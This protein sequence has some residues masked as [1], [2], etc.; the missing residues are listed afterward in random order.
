[1]S[2]YRYIIL[3]FS[4]FSLFA[5]AQENEEIEMMEFG[6]FDHWFVREIEE[7][8]VVGGN[9]LYIYSIGKSDTLRNNESIKALQYSPWG[10]SNVMARIAGITK[11]TN[12]VFPVKRDNGYCARIET[13]LIELKALGFVN[14][15][16]VTAGAIYLGGASEPVNDPN[17]LYINV[18]MG[19]PFNKKPKAIMLD[20]RSDM[21]NLTTISRSKPG[22]FSVKEF[23]G[24]DNADVFCFLQKRWEDKDGNIYA[25]RVGTAREFFGEYNKKWV[26]NHRI[27]II[28][29]NATKSPDYK[30]YMKLT[31]KEK[32]FYARN[33]KGEM[34][35]VI[36]TDWG[37]ENDEVTHI[38][39][40][41]SSGS[42]GAYEGGLNNAFLVDNIKFV[43]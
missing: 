39:F 18:D 25:K 8:R 29:G 30:D 20:Y 7:S 9:T 6:D 33:S 35:P 28:Y 38:V 3:F 37:S 26:N 27:N 43:Y 11:G 40:M 34:V 14:I 31:P 5:Q 32:S 2:R 12:T 24:Q 19:I 10:T 1:M 42:R 4:L 13:R 36:E 21:K 23:E 22:S 16:V 41:V 17:N 15:K